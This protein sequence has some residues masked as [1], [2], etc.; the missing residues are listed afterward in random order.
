MKTVCILVTKMH[1]IKTLHNSNHQI[2]N[3]LPKITRQNNGLHYGFQSNSH[4]SKIRI[5][6]KTSPTL[7][8]Y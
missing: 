2:R 7:A 8:F 5:Y 3:L 1:L 6:Y 4:H